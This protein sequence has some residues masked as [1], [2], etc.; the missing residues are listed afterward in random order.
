MIAAPRT[1]SCRSLTLPPARGPVSS[2]LVQA[3]RR[4]PGAAGSWPTTVTSADP[5]GDEDLQLALYLCYEL[6]YTGS[7]ASTAWEWD[8]SLLAFRA[9]PWSAPSRRR[10][11]R[12]SRRPGNGSWQRSALPCSESS[13][14]RRPAA[15][16]LPG[17]AG[18]A[19][20]DAASYVVHRSA[21]QLKEADPHSWAI[22]R[23][24]GRAQ[25]GA[26]G[27]PGRRVRRRPS[28]SACTRRCSP[29]RWT[30]LGLD[31]TYG[32][33]LDRLPGVDAGD[34]QPDVAVRPAPAPAR[35]ARRP[36]RRVRDDLLDAQP[37]LRQRRCAGSARRRGDAT[38]TTSTSRPTPSTSRSPPGTWPAAWP[39][40]SRRSPP[41]S[42]SAPGRCCRS[43]RAGPRH[44]IEAW[45]REEQLAAGR[46]A[47]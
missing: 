1:A 27:D 8:P 23:L 3:L 11:A 22:P 37:P 28:R 32:A 17:D 12:A 10:C 42:S 16:P 43:R 40:P 13:R 5:I 36:P 31:A 18:D 20:A 33:Y 38:S 14:R 6:H 47:A 45:E 15:V 4:E 26:G 34:G 2:A 29:R 30:R 25:G 9:Q 35:R 44:L 21:Y 24:A 19:R 7:S 39:P 41:T 46:A